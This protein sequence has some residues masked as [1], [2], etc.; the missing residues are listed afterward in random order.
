MIIPVTR[1]I[2]EMTGE[3][4]RLVKCRHCGCEFVYTLVRSARGEARGVMILESESGSSAAQQRAASALQTALA[5]ECDPVRCP[6]C[7][8]LQP[9]MLRELRN[10][11]RRII[12]KRWGWL[13]GVGVV[14]TIIAAVYEVVGMRRLRDDQYAHPF[15]APAG[16]ITLAIGIALLFVAEIAAAS[17][18]D[19]STSGVDRFGTPREE[20]EREAADPEAS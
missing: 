14:G 16:A 4:A 8:L 17:V 18:K 19:G 9:E 15:A 3:V 20:F 12:W 1:H 5:T 6:S 2:A 10:R 7:E 13:L 11:K